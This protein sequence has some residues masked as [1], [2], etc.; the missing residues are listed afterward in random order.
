M[1]EKIIKTETER[2][3][4]RRIFAA[5]MIKTEEVKK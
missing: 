3:E 2:D 1:L 5:L 4:A